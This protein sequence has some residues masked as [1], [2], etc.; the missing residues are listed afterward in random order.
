MPHAALC[1]AARTVEGFAREDRVLALVCGG[2]APAG[3]G[4]LLEKAAAVAVADL[5]VQ[6][7]QPRLLH[8][9]SLLAT[10]PT[11]GKAQLAL[12]LFARQDVAAEHATGRAMH[13]DQSAV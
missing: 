5:R 10:H 11:Q 6:V 3:C 13:S 4:P 2:A 12:R 8:P 7:A 9:P 1:H